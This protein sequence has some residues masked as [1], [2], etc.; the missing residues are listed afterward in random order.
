MTMGMDAGRGEQL[1]IIMKSTIDYP[2]GFNYYI[3]PTQFTRPFPIIPKK[4]HP[5]NA[6]SSKARTLLSV[7]HLDAT[8]K[9]KRPFTASH[10][11]NT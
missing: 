10:T 11:P 7:S 4:A 5:I 8:L 2:V 3:S 6:S 1:R 9:P